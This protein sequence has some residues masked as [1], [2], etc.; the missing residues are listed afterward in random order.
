MN[1]RE[2]N[3]SSLMAI[4][5]PPFNN[6]NLYE[7]P[8]NIYVTVMQSPKNH[9]NTMIDTVDEISFHQ[10]QGNIPS[11]GERDHELLYLNQTRACPYGKVLNQ[12]KVLSYS[13]CKSPDLEQGSCI[14]TM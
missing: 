10:E 1:H 12:K 6:E 5:S 4:T 14:V 2:A 8:S 3:L 7:L 11:Y 9:I 13:H